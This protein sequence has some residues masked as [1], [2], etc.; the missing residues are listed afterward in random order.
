MLTRGGVARQWGRGDSRARSSHP[1]G[2]GVVLGKG[3]ALAGKG[4][5]KIGIGGMLLCDQ[6]GKT[7][8]GGAGGQRFFVN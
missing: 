4:L 7:G 3:L 8:A 5:Q 2:I 1:E 6:G